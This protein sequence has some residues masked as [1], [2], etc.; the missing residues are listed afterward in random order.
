M[1]KKRKSKK[2]LSLWGK[3]KHKLSSGWDWMKNLLA[4]SWS[5][6]GDHEFLTGLLLILFAGV[7]HFGCMEPWTAV[8]WLA[9]V[10]GGKRVYDILKY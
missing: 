7:L 3:M 1:K 2:S 4:D 5:Y 6:L 10:W 8:K 9:L